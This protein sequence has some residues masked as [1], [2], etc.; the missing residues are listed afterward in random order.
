MRAP[1][2]RAGRVHVTIVIEL[3]AFIYLQFS[4]HTHGPLRICNDTPYV[5]VCVYVCV[6]ACAGV[7]MCVCVRVCRRVCVSEC[8]C[9]CVNLCVCVYAVVCVCVVCVRA[10]T[11]H[12]L[13]PFLF[14]LIPRSVVITTLQIRRGRLR[15]LRIKLKKITQAL[16][17]T[18]THTH[19][20]T[21]T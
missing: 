5:C 1:R 11:A 8:V 15:S 19:T 18:H 7:C 12:R 10:M 20:Y 9:V 2:G 16:T 4:V 3:R 21:H 17:H 6:S 13:N 14:R